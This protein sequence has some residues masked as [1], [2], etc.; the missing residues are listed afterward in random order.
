MIGKL[1][2]ASLVGWGAWRA[3][4]RSG[5][6]PTYTP[7]AQGDRMTEIAARFGVPVEV[8]VK[9]NGPGFAR[10]YAPNGDPVTFRLPKGVVDGGAR[11][12]AQ[13]RFAS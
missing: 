8:I 7:A 12:G 2:I 13:G 10:F 11:I 1:T 9:A 5:V 3:W 6:G 4:K